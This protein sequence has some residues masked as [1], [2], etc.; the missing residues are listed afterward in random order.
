MKKETKSPKSKK[1]KLGKLQKA[2]VESLL[3][4]PERQTDKILG[5]GTPKKYTACCLGEMHLTAFRLKKKKLPFENNCIIADGSKEVLSKVYEEYGLISDIGEFE[6]AVVINDKTYF[7][8]SEMNDRGI[9]WK[10][11]ANYIKQNP[12]NVFTKSV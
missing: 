12:E 2:W 5:E 1:F 7:A 10:E 3:A 4:H 11:I 9:T 6:E 8:L